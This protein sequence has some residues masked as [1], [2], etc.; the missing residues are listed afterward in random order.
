MPRTSQGLGALGTLDFET[1]VPGL[2]DFGPE[3][4]A[5]GLPDFGPDEPGFG[6][7][8]LGFLDLLPDFEPP[9]PG[10]P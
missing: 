5:F 7:L 9:C 4:P 3:E 1:D 2:S 6:L 8:D 10:F